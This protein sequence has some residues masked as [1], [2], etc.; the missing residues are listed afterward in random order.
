M[1]RRTHFARRRSLLALTGACLA[2]A[3]LAS[4]A[5]AEPWGQLGRLD[6]GRTETRSGE[7][8]AGKVNLPYPSHG[9]NGEDD[10]LAFA[11][12]AADAGFYIADQLQ[13]PDAEDKYVARFRIQRFEADGH[14]SA[15][16]VFSTSTEGL[17]VKK[18]Q[19]RLGATGLELAVDP[20]RNRV[21]ALVRYERR[22]VSKDEE[23]EQEKEEKQ[24]EREEEE[25]KKGKKPVGS[26]KKAYEREPLDAEEQAAGPLYAFEYTGGKLVSAKTGTKGEALALIA[27]EGETASFQAQGEKP[28]QALLNPHGLAVDPTTG[29]V[30]VVGDQ[31]EQSA[32]KVEKGEAQKQCRAAAQWVAIQQTGGHVTGASLAR[33]YVDKTNTLGTAIGEEACAEQEVPYAPYSPVLT[34]HGRLLAQ[35]GEG[36]VWQLG[37]EEPGTSFEELAMPVHRVFALEDLGPGDTLLGDPVDGEDSS[38]PSLSLLPE[39]GA[40]G[41]SEGKLYLTADRPLGSK[42]AV[43]VL[44]YAESEGASGPLSDQVLGWLGGTTPPAGDESNEDCVIANSKIGGESA[45]LG[46]YRQAGQEGVLA[47]T[48]VPVNYANPKLE[49]KELIV[50]KLGPGGSTANCPQPQVSRP[51]AMVAG[52]AVQTLELGSAAGVSATVAEANATSV[53]WRFDY[54]SPQAALETALTGFGAESPELKSHLFEHYGECLVEAVVHSDD[55]MAPAT[56]ASREP[57]ALTVEPAPIRI[58]IQPRPAARAGEATRFEATVVDPNEEA[59]GL[60][61]TW[62]FGDGASLTG[63]TTAAAHRALLTAEHSYSAPGSYTVTLEVQDEAYGL[64]QLPP[65]LASTEVA[66]GEGAQEEAV[67]REEEANHRAAAI[68]HQ[69]EEVKRQEEANQQAEPEAVRYPKTGVLPFVSSQGDP[70]ARL[71][72]STLSVSAAGAVPVSVTCP[73]GETSCTGT[74]TLRT[75]NA[76]SARKKKAIL[77]LASGAFTVAG[78]RTETITLHLSSQARALLARSHTLHALATILA[79][80]PTGAS[81]T[82]KTIVTLRPAARPH[83]RR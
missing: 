37:S 52:K 46:A 41:E 60:S 6:L 34:P 29:D 63:A 33:R 76:V 50:A 51:T 27:A 42:E 14:A 82:V 79:H 80:D 36:Q 69:Q 35:V 65:A 54:T 68:E 66:A 56:V 49:R 25:E 11:V 83:H 70:E 16:V 28:K 47:F 23:K 39:E 32:E 13:A 53:Q 77:T 55:L 72:S 81:R 21:Y 12:D 9:A 73:R 3:L 20:S 10:G 17:E 48:P 24:Q 5:R 78:G 38:N 61:Y 74:V 8:E 7:A 71:A 18:E 26:H 57:L 44:H 30:L 43:L 31:D 19:G 64:M 22:G 62:R 45:L 4:S 2:L 59:G 40:A 15:S 75:L 58:A 1:T 67:K